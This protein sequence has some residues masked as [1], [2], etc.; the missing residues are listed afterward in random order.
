MEKLKINTATG[1]VNI[2]MAVISL[3]GPGFTFLMGLGETLSTLGEDYSVTAGFIVFFRILFIIALILNI[4]SLVK[5]KQNNFQ[6]TGQIC[7]IVGAGL[8]ILFGGWT[9]IASLVLFI[10]AAV[11]VLKHKKINVVEESNCN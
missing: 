5:S 2:V 3:I 4:I 8:Y 1:I 11:F 6:I 7:G 10:L 9:A